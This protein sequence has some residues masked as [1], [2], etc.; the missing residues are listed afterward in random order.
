[1]GTESAKRAARPDLCDGP[2][3]KF[4]SVAFRPRPV[5]PPFDSSPFS[6]ENNVFV[7]PRARVGDLSGGESEGNEVKSV[8]VWEEPEWRFCIL[9]RTILAFRLLL[10]AV[11][12]WDEER[13]WEWK[14]ESAMTQQPGN[15][16]D[17]GIVD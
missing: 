17:G 16:V 15:G 1:M 14:S 8:V 5:P 11:D 2:V 12:A 4:A 7:R 3:V 10:E 6:P 9:V 13:R